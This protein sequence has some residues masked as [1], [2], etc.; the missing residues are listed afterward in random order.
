MK[1][2]AVIFL[3]WM[4]VSATSAWGDRVVLKDGRTFEGVVR[5]SG[6]QVLIEMEL[7]TISVPVSQVKQIERKPTA[8][9][10]FERRLSRID[11]SDPAAL[12][13]LAIWAREKGLHRQCQKLLEQV[14]ALQPDNKKARKLLGFVEVD[15]KWVKFS[16]ALQLARAKLEAGQ[17]EVL[18]KKVVPSL[19]EVAANDS[20]VLQVKRIEAYGTLRAK[21]FI[22]AAECFKRLAEKTLPPESI[23]Y[24]AIAEILAEHPSGMYVISETYPPTA[25]LLGSAG[26]AVDPGP[27]S[28]ARPEVLKAALRSRAKQFI[29]KGKDLLMQGKKLESVNS[30]TAKVKYNL[31]EELFKSADAIVPNIARSWRVEIARRRIAMITSDMNAQAARF[32]A[33]KAELGKRDLTPAAYVNLINRMQV[34]LKRIHEDLQLI[35]KLASPYERELVL[36]VTDAKYRLQR[37]EALQ[38]VLRQEMNGK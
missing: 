1:R 6:G 17:Y 34:I 13:E 23:R 20:Q 33:L 27:A 36:D 9:E 38:G 37:I 32:D 35:L 18:L 29:K 16:V 2:T 31:A 12:I 28:L 3:L 24:G 4:V 14:V 19:L 22:R 10:L 25:M 7:G 30:D 8:A 5:Q 15:G 11:Q 21:Q 26:P